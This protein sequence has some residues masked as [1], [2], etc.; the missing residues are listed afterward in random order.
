MRST[1]S[2]ALFLLAVIPIVLSSCATGGTTVVGN[3]TGG[4]VIISGDPKVLADVLGQIATTVSDVVKSD[5]FSKAAQDAQTAQQGQ[6]V[7]PQ[8][9]KQLADVAAD[10]SQSQTTRDNANKALKLLG[11]K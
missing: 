5:F 7:D 2:V 8:L 11:V 4:T 10:S 3:A 6:A 1:R 9:Q